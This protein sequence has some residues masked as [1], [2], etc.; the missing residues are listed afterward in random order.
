M[1]WNRPGLSG[2][3]MDVGRERARRMPVWA[4]GSVGW[5]QEKEMGGGA[6]RGAKKCFG[7]EGETGK[8]KSKKLRIFIK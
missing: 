1:P 5:K 7:C 8:G 2:E 3:P 6:D 4:R